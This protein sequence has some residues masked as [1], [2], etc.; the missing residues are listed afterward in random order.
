MKSLIFVGFLLVMTE[1]WR[2]P[3]YTGQMFPNL[4]H[5][6][7]P[8]FDTFYQTQPRQEKIRIKTIWW[9]IRAFVEGTN[10]DK[11]KGGL[12]LYTCLLKTVLNYTSFE[13]RLAELGMPVQF[14]L[15]GQNCTAFLTAVGQAPL[16]FNCVYGIDP[17]CSSGRTNGSIGLNISCKV[18]YDI[19]TWILIII[20][21]SYRQGVVGSNTQR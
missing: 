8:H 13:N 21:S 19:H 17:S 9:V 7:F 2:S 4:L 18:G 1:A 5:N 20:F 15:G 6:S 3:S 11:A 12:K 14:R 10:G 16:Q